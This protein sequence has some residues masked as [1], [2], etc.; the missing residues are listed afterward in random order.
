MK[1]VLYSL[2]FAG[3]VTASIALFLV[4]LVANAV[5]DSGFAVGQIANALTKAAPAG[6]I[7]GIFFGAALQRRSN[8]VPRP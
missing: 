7:A 1:L 3:F 5:G 6:V 8:R 4:Y 2:V